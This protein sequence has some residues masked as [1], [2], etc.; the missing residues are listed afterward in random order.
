VPP[1]GALG[2]ARQAKQPVTGTGEVAEADR[3]LARR[4]AGEIGLA[5]QPQEV[6]ITRL[7]LHQQHDPVRLG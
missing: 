7:A 5:H 4:F 1:G 6:A 2:A 3:G